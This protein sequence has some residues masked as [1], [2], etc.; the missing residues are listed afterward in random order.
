MS[1]IQTICVAYGTMP[2][3]Q[4]LRGTLMIEDEEKF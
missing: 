3:G 4:I 2:L 1:G